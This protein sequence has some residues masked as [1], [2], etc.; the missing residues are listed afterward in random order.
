[1]LRNHPP[2]ALR[3]ANRKT[4]IVMP[5]IQNQNPPQICRH[6]MPTPNFYGG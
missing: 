4:G 1:L 2:E 3:A 6:C 5:E